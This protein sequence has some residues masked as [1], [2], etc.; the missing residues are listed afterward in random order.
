MKMSIGTGLFIAGILGAIVFGVLD[1][2]NIFP[3]AAWMTWTLVFISLGVGALNINNDEAVPF[4][5]ATLIIGA[6]SGLFTIIPAVG[7]W[8]D[9]MLINISA[10]SLPAA[11]LVGI[12]T[13]ATGAYK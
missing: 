9:T 3:Y 2:F 1:A 12:K 4:M 6:G 10:L 11:I 5:V 13:I 7:G 8:I